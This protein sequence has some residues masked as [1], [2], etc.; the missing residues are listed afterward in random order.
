MR[1][2]QTQTPEGADLAFGR[3]NLIW[4]LDIEIY[5]LLIGG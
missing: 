1:D 4:S 3:L 2:D 5:N